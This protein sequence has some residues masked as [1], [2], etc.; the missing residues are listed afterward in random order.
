MD[1]APTTSVTLRRVYSV[2][3][4]G[5]QVKVKGNSVIE[6]SVLVSQCGYFK[7]RYY[8]LADDSCRASGNTLQLVFTQNNT[9]VVRHNTITGEG[10]VLIG[11]IEGDTSNKVLIQN[12]VITGFPTYR[13]PTILSSLYYANA[14]G[15]VASYSGNLV[16]KVKGNTCPSGSICGQDPKLTN[17]TLATFDAEPLAGSPVIDK[18]PMI[19]AVT[20]DFLL[21]KRPSG[22]ANDIGAYEMQDGTALPPPPA[23]APAPT[24][25]HAAPTLV[26]TGPTTAVAAGTQN[27]YA[28][29]LKNNDGSGCSNTTF[30]LARTVPSGWTGSLSVASVALAPGASA[31]ATLAVTSTA[32]AA[33]GSYG[34]GVGTSSSVGS[35]HTSNASTTYVVSAPVGLTETVGTDKSAYIAGQKVYMSARVLKG[36]VAVA[37][38]TV[39]FVAVK[40]NSV[41]KVTLSG[42]TDSNGYA[43]VTLSTSKSPS[44]IG[45]YQLT[46][47]AVSGGQTATANT[48]FSVSK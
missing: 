38:A 39:S 2:A 25:T 9:A 6:N 21:Q 1:G 32:T 41:N 26:L 7:D 36:S 47:S 35:V 46:A 42:T 34:I 10:G 18:A 44:S 30:V 43:R 22:A 8:M 13:D 20:T 31:N 45:T 15:V 33:A 19:S 24:C 17:M 12:N 28:L 29:N 37:G 48:S 23:P 3:N 11:A 40:P 5:N 27:T 14:T 4:A 16:W